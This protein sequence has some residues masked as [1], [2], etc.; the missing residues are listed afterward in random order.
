MGFFQL[1]FFIITILRT[2]INFH[3]D[4]YIFKF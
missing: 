1:E 2:F 3:G 4:L